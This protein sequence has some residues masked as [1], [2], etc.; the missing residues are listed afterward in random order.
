MLV[1][2]L[3]SSFGVRRALRQRNK[4]RQHGFWWRT[5]EDFSL[6]I[7]SMLLVRGDMSFCGLCFVVLEGPSSDG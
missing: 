6:E 4:P 1:V 2:E 3:L 7:I 5:E